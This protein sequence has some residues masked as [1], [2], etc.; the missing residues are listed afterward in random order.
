M[1]QPG[2]PAARATAMAPQASTGPRQ[3]RTFDPGVS[4]FIDLL[5]PDGDGLLEQLDGAAKGREAI[6]AVGGADGDEDARL[7]DPQGPD[8]VDDVDRHLR[9]L[10]PHRRLDPLHLAQG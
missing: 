2:A 10:R 7:P 1:A 6:G 9:P 4:I 5:L 3:L 8:P